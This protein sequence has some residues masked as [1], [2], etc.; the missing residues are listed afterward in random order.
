MKRMTLILLAGASLFTLTACGQGTAI[1]R[2][3]ISVTGTGEV[4][5]EPD[6]FLVSATAR[7]EGD[8]IDALKDRVD[9]AVSDMLELA[10][11]LDIPEKQV[12]ASDLRIS[13]Q[14]QYQPE[15][16]L[17]GHQVSR[18]V[19][20]RVS[21][22]SVYTRLL[23][24]LASQNVQDLH[25]AGTEISNVDIHTDRALEKAVDDARR[26]AERIADAADRSVG[27]AIRI[28]AQNVQ[29]PR[30]VMMMARVKEDAAG[31]SYRPG[32]TEIS[33]QVSITFELE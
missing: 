23:D 5:A 7:Q 29:V 32:E 10:D 33:A 8:D 17:L 2:D 12:R 14:W 30:P 27:E 26:R 4:H 24:G 9:D 20:F 6:I 19:T 15:R 28:E 3:T 31:G 21:G 1:D 25:P 18:D 16:K 11:D 22:M 13:P